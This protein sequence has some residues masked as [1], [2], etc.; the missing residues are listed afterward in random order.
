MKVASPESVRGWNILV[1]SVPS[2]RD[3]VILSVPIRC[4][5]RKNAVGPTKSH[6]PAGTGRFFF[7]SQA[8]NC[9]A[10]APWKRTS[11]QEKDLHC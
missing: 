1:K 9:L 10:S 11:P 2:R 3:D 7:A 4:F 5:R 6:R 8:V